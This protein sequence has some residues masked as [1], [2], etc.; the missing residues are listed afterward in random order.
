MHFI[1]KTPRDDDPDPFY[2]EGMEVMKQEC[3][4]IVDILEQDSAKGNFKALI[5]VYIPRSN[6][7][8]DEDRT[9]LDWMETLIRD[10]LW[11]WEDH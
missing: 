3:K 6:E 2:Q 5:K 9:Y 8:A 11:E 1:E 7:L 10:N 4:S